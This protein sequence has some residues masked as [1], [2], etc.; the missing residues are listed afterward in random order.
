MNC[1]RVSFERN[2]KKC[3][4]DEVNEIDYPNASASVFFSYRMCRS[5]VL[6][7]RA[8]SFK[9]SH[10]TVLVSTVHG[11]RKLYNFSVVKQLKQHKK[12]LMN[13]KYTNEIEIYFFLSLY[14]SVC[15]CIC[16]LNESNNQGACV[17]VCMNFALSKKII[18]HF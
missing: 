2:K 10:V 3:D 4:A 7:H 1:A 9:S 8:N 16:V 14:V 13:L 17:C 11:E 6:R 15:A 5:S 18:I 12:M